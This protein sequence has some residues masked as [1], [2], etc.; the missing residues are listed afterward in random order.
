MSSFTVLFL[1]LATLLLLHTGITAENSWRIGSG[2][3]CVITAHQILWGARTR[4]AG[5]EDLQLSTTTLTNYLLNSGTAFFVI[6]N[7]WNASMSGQFWPFMAAQI[8]TFGAACWVFAAL[9]IPQRHGE[10]AAQRSD[11]ADSA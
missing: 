5:R 1:S 3:W 11:E 4:Y 8:W 6:L 7:V 10:P 2:I 9:L